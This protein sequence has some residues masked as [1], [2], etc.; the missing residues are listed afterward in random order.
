MGST[1]KTCTLCFIGRIS[2]FLTYLMFW[3][4]TN[5]S[6]NSSINTF[7]GY[8]S[9]TK[10]CTA[11][12]GKLLAV[13]ACATGA[14]RRIS[15]RAPCLLLLNIDEMYLLSCL[16]LLY[17]TY[18]GIA[19]VIQYI[20]NGKYKRCISLN[21]ANRR[22]YIVAFK[23][24]KIKLGSFVFRVCSG[25]PWINLGATSP[26]PLS[27]LPSFLFPPFFI[28]LALPLPRFCRGL[29][30]KFIHRRCGSAVSSSNGVW[31]KSTAVIDFWTFWAWKIRSR[32]Q[33]EEKV[34][35][36]LY[37]NSLL[38]M[39][40]NTFPSTF[41][42]KIFLQGLN[43]LD[44]RRC[45]VKRIGGAD[46][47]NFPTDE[48]MGAQNNFDPKFSQNRTFPVQ[49]FTF[50]KKNF[51][52]IF[53]QPNITSPTTT[54]LRPRQYCRW[55]A[56]RP[57]PCKQDRARLINTIQYSFITMADRPLRKWHRLLMTCRRRS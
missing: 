44:Q 25:A 41:W 29:F 8:Y 42:R 26:I 15:E 37:T 22:T 33:A 47:C 17:R 23:A 35:P 31:S 6:Q 11:R 16:R 43:G 36:K 27:L 34:G 57:R 5:K 3:K 40:K 21:K 9:E 39:A 13:G 32:G 45:G 50:W 2:S 7:N 28:S 51:N 1:V 54:P 10:S 48:I 38:R 30:S 46:S 52:K 12:N 53:L 14:E 49:N 20:K 56:S 55:D 4:Q 19:V 24:G 18:L